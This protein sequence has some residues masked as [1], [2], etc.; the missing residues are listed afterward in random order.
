MTDGELFHFPGDE[1]GFVLDRLYLF[2]AND[3]QD[4]RFYPPHAT[5][6]QLCFKL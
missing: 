6:R 5:H 4:V 3:P 1:V 2:I